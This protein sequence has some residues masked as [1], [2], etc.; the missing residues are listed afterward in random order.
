VIATAQYNF[1]SATD[2]D[3]A[4]QSAGHPPLRAKMQK[5]GWLPDAWGFEMLL[6]GSSSARREQFEWKYSRGP[7]VAALEGRT[8]GLK[9]V[10]VATG[11]VVCAWAWTAVSARKVG[12]LRWVLGERWGEEVELMVLVT[13]LAVVERVRRDESGS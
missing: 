10:R 13:L 5:T 2:I 4:P 9:C 3:I 12:K 6:P 8:R 7:E 1:L 11:E